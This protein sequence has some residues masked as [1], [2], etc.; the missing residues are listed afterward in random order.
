MSI[1]RQIVFIYI[2]VVVGTILYNMGILADANIY[3]YKGNVEEYL[4]LLLIRSIELFFVLLIANRLADIWD[5]ISGALSG[6][7]LGYLLS[8]HAMIGNIW[9]QLAYSI[10]ALIIVILY[11]TIFDLQNI[12]GGIAAIKAD[13]KLHNS[14][15]QNLLVIT[16]LLIN[17]FLELKI[18]KLF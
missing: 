18:V 13:S 11:M 9:G 7:L 12:P 16:I 14:I 3:E 6:F 5:I 17:V 15:I 1:K 8:S 10:I 4:R 2:G